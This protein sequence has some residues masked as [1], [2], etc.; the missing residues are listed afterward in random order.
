V[1]D[2][3]LFAALVLAVSLAGC[4]SAGPRDLSS[5]FVTQGVPTVDLG[6]IA[7]AGPARKAARSRPSSPSHEIVSGIARHGGAS[8]ALET[9]DAGLRAALLEVQL[10]PTSASH[11]RAAAAYRKAGITDQA[12]DHLMQSVR[13][14]AANAAAHDLMARM[15]RD[16]GLPGTGLVEAH[17]AIYYAPRSAAARNTLGTLLSALGQRQEAEQAFRAATAVEPDAWFAARNLCD[18]VMRSGRT[19]EAIPLCQRAD[20]LES[21][22]RE[23]L[24]RAAPKDQR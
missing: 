6:G 8:S 20:A 1:T 3:R 13:L 17:R 2:G 16:W 19:K 24:K 7:P 12:F 10:L 23:A 15:W 14:D 18:I 5:H 4:A 9:Q 22:H 21:A 11:L